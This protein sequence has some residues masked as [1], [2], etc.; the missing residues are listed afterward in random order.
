MSKKRI[1]I[2]SGYFNPIHKGHIE[3]FHK[4]R[5]KGEFLFVIV[6]NDKQRKLKGSKEFMYEN[7][8]L[9]ILSEL[10][11]IDKVFLSIDQDYSVTKTL[12][13]I[14]SLFSKTHTLFF[15]NGGDQNNRIIPEFKICQ[16]LG[17]ELIHG[18]GKKVQSSSWLLDRL[19]ENK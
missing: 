8:R 6:N 16:N 12:E 9:L 14:N 13:K 15:G 18:L 1:I 4:A 11:I 19:N 3:L 2:V 5:E 7:E 10:K 17:I